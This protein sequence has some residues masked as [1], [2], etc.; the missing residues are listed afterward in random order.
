MKIEQLVENLCVGLGIKQIHL[1]ALLDVSSEA[2][3]RAR[4]DV[5]D[6]EAKTKIMR[7]LDALTYAIYPLLQEPI[8]PITRLSAIKRSCI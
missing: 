4:N 7:R 3:T 2:I 1:A 5:F 8:N 6:P